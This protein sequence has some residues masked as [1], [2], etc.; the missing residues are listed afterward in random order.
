MYKD[1]K[2]PN[3][4]SQEDC[5]HIPQLINNI[6]NYFTRKAA[7]RVEDKLKKDSISESFAL[8]N[9]NQNPSRQKQKTRG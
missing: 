6:S 4:L 3:G 7:L 8:K 1:F 2:C 5:R 9:T